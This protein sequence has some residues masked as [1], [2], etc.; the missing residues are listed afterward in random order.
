[1]G[2]SKVQPV[3]RSYPLN[4]ER[5]AL[6]PQAQVIRPMPITL[7][8]MQELLT[9]ELAVNGNWVVANLDTGIPW[10][11]KL[12]KVTFRNR[13]L[14]LLPPTSTPLPETAPIPSNETYP[15]LRSG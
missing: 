5:C 6:W 7:P 4:E 1:M 9:G 3:E 12:V 15:C 14:F 2:W 10:P 8:S 11:T 13:I